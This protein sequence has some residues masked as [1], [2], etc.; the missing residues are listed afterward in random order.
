MHQLVLYPSWQSKL[1]AE[2]LDARKRVGDSDLDYDTLMNLPYLDALV[3]ETT[4]V[5]P[6][7]SVLQ[8]V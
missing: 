7:F 5:F 6:P 1:R 2:V 8:R 4:R 3:R